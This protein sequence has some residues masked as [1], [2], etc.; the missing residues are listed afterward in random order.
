[1]VQGTLTGLKSVLMAYVGGV[2]DGRPKAEFNQ[3]QTINR[4]KGQ[5]AMLTSLGSEY[6]LYRG[7]GPLLWS[8]SPNVVT[9]H[10]WKRLQSTAGF[11]P[12]YLQLQPKAAFSSSL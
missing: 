5:A 2:P 4:A 3:L 7:Q 11:D 1:M 9:V 12:S 6:G 10:D 8:R